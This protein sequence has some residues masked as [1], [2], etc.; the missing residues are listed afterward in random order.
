MDP[1]VADLLRIAGVL[2]LVALNGVFVAAEFALVSVRWTRVEE[3]V[4]EGKFGALAVREAVENL[5][6]A[7]AAAQL[8]ITLA[9]IALGWLGEPAIAHLLTP[10]FCRDS[11][12]VECRGDPRHRDRRGLLAT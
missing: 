9:S 1:Y 4:E 11:G 2:V 6:D 8:G 7:I 10:V 5:D 12:A 3:M